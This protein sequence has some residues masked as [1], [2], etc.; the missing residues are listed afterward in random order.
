MAILNFSAPILPGKFD[1]WKAFHDTLYVGGENHAKW[2]DQMRRYNIE[3][4]IVSLQR[5]PHGDFVVVFFEGPE[6][7]AMMVD[8]GTSDNEFDQWFAK[9]V[10]EVHGI[11][12]SKPPP[13]PISEFLLEYRAE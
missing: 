3:R 1:Q 11:E 7:A 2:K 10:N 4:Q 12:V 9:Q 6:P 13:G 8:L 5:T